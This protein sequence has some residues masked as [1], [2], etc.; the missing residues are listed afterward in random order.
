M[1]I[2]IGESLIYSWLRHV[3]G[4]QLVQTNWKASPR[5][6]LLHE[7]ELLKILNSVDSMLKE[8]YGYA[9][10]KRNASLMQVLQQTECDLV[11]INVDE[12][13]IY[14]VESAF[15]ENG[16]N[17]GGFGDTVQKVLA[18]CVRNALCIYGYLDSIKNV[19]VLFVSPKAGKSLMDRLGP[20]VQDV[21]D[22]MKQLGYKKIQFRVIVNDEFQNEVLN[23]VLVISGDVNDTNELFVRSYH[24]LMTGDS[25]SRVEIQKDRKRRREEIAKYM[26]ESKYSNYKVGQ[27]AQIV[28]RNILEKGISEELLGKLKTKE[29]SKEIF[30]LNYPLLVGDDDEY[31]RRRYYV[32]PVQIN[33]K[34]YLLCKEWFEYNR[35]KLEK[36]IE[37]NE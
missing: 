33:G 7:E 18:K 1:K 22:L 5:W 6:D 30:G 34:S 35:E 23:K 36:W 29:S 31:Q 2:E 24:M 11:G 25:G 12:N 13:K 10:F 20:C 15:H 17:Y 37:E 14:V 28:L 4:C 9:V 26:S 21:Q 32:E 3:N 8:K 19:D 27:I 16:L